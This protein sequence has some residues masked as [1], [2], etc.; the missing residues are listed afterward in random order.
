[1]IHLSLVQIGIAL[2]IVVAAVIAYELQTRNRW[3]TA[4]KKQVENLAHTPEQLAQK[5]P[6]ELRDMLTNAR[7]IQ[8]INAAYIQHPKIRESDREQARSLQESTEQQIEILRAAI[9][10]SVKI[11]AEQ[12]HVTPAHA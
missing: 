11:R 5:H 6:N 10:E 7:D 4:R 8:T 3:T 1:M 2:S 12:G 9:V